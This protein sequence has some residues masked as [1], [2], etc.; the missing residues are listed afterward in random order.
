MK[1]LIYIVSWVVL[2]L[3]LSFLAHAF[4]E[5]TYINFALSRGMV[6]VD[7]TAFGRGY[8]VLPNWLQLLLPV[9]GAVGG[10]AS[11]KFFWRV[12]FKLWSYS[13]E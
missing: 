3:L 13:R 12:K 11:G 9:L 7:Q 1:R 4:I 10:Y 6:L 8:C 2:G 5:I